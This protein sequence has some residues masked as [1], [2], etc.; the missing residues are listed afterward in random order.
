MLLR[1]WMSRKHANSVDELCSFLV[2]AG[3]ESFWQGIDAVILLSIALSRPPRGPEGS[4][5]STSIAA[6]ACAC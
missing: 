1:L 2:S 6:M 4:L 3:E 5:D